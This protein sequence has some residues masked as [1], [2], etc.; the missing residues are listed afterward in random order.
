MTEQKNN[1][2]KH[3]PTL[4]PP[5]RQYRHGIPLPCFHISCFTFH[6][7][8]FLLAGCSALD[9][10]QFQEAETLPP[11]EGTGG[12]FVAFGPNFFSLY[13]DSANGIGGIYN[14][15][16]GGSGRVGLLEN[17]DLGG[18]AWASNFPLLGTFAQSYDLGLR[19]DA[20]WMVTPR[21][22]E[23]RLALT[24]GIDGYYSVDARY[25]IDGEPAGYGG[26]WSYGP[27]LIY[28]YSWGPPM[29]LRSRLRS[30]YLG[31]RLVRATSS[32]FYVSRDSLLALNGHEDHTKMIATVWN[33]FLGFRAGDV[34][35]EASGIVVPDP[36]TGTERWG[37]YFGLQ[38]P[39][40]AGDQ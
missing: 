39:A 22:W 4:R 6:I 23:Q 7:L 1:W 30:L 20:K 25:A 17:V 38:L 34:F 33:P 32:Y 9:P 14:P 31:T 26:T 29:K 13:R 19:A 12:P 40:S 24:V 11:G 15:I 36:R 8:L 10:M 35:I 27:G 5:S 21:E 28:S 3:A 16:I 2:L 37:L 18:G